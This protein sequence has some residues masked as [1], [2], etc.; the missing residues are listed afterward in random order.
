MEKKLCIDIAGHFSSVS[1]TA[2]EMMSLI[3]DW[4]DV[5]KMQD[6]LGDR[7]VREKLGRLIDAAKL[8]DGRAYEQIKLLHGRI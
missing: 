6:H 3:G 2:G 4:G 7:S 1:K 8:E 5:E